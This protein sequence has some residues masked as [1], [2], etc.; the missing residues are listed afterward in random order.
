MKR[1][2]LFFLFSSFSVCAFPTPETAHHSESNSNEAMSTQPNSASLPHSADTFSWLRDDSRQSKKVRQYLNEHNQQAELFLEQ[3]TALQQQLLKEWQDNAPQKA[4]K[5]WLIRDDVK[6][7][8]ETRDNARV[9]VE[10]PTNQASENSKERVVFNLTQ[11]AA[12]SDYYSLGS[13][14]LSPNK[15]FIAVTEDIRGDRNYAVTV[16]DTHTQ[17]TYSLIQNVSTELIWGND[18]DT[19]YVI[20]NE[21]G[22]YRPYQLVKTQ[23]SAPQKT[24]V[25]LEETDPAWLLSSYKTGNE[26]YAIVQSNN[27]NTSQQQLLDTHTGKLQASLQVR[28]SG[29]EYYSDIQGQQIISLSN[30]Q[31]HF[32]LY[33][34]KI[35]SN[36]QSLEPLFIPDPQT[37]IKNWY[38]FEAGIALVLTQQGKD[39]LLVINDHGDETFR[40]PLSS[41]GKVA[42]LSNNG[43]AAS[44]LVRIRSMSMTTPP[45]WSEFNIATGKERLLSQDSYPTIE[46]SDYTS[47]QITVSA[48]GV[49][50]PVS[51]AY[52]NDKISPDSPVFLYGY[53]AYGTPM[54]P[55]FMPQVISLLDQGAIYAISHVRGGGYL[56][57]AWYQAGKGIN[58]P[59][60][61]KD[62]LATAEVMQRYV[63]SRDSLSSSSHDASPTKSQSTV[64]RD[65]LAIG[66]SAGGTL[67]AA[68]INAQPTL[69]RGAVL[70]AP[71]VDVINTMADPSLPLTQQEYQEWGNPAKADERKVMETYSPYDNIRAQAYPPMLVRIGL[72]DSQVPYWEGAKFVAKLQQQ[73]TVNNPYLLT[74]DFNAGHQKN[75]R[76]AQAAQA[77]EYAFLLDLNKRQASSP[78]VTTTNK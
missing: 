9:L 50:V 70:Q 8:F 53:G 10:K 14:S 40:R 42:W 78:V 48:N 43:D 75:R 60:S 62:F 26:K 44:N 35:G 61:I 22:T 23:L 2:A 31:G 59:N 33:Q 34:G 18:N 74:T 11:R 47:T 68:A 32:G 7:R 67:V 15:R 27:H 5:P 52:R 20:A 64:K 25:L 1:S 51:L 13:W 41:E 56:G 6:Y 3:Q 63:P 69:F 46:P 4:E 24:D 49:N 29:N 16:I 76:T 72:H 38:V 19:L 73:S 54:K 45:T 39:T 12:M 17:K 58:K 57:D 28:S 37:E 65:I 66:G 55:Y 71:F 30:H 21:A 77:M 36:I